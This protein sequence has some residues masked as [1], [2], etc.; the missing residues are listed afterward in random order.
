MKKVTLSFFIS[1]TRSSYYLFIAAIILFILNNSVYPQSR[2]AHG[3]LE[4]VPSRSR[5][6][7]IEKLSTTQDLDYTVEL[8]PG[9]GFTGYVYYWTWGSDT[10]NAHL[11]VPPEASSWLTVDPTSFS[12]DSCNDIKEV[13]FYFYAPDSLGDYETTVVDLDSNYSDVH[14][15]LI[16]TDAPS[17]ATIEGSVDQ[18]LQGSD[19]A[20]APLILNY[21]KFEMGCDTSYPPGNNQVVVLIIHPDHVPWLQLLDTVIVLSVNTPDT[22]NVP[23]TND[24]TGSPYDYIYYSA[25][26]YAHPAYWLYY[27]SGVMA[28]RG[29]GSEVI[30]QKFHLSQNYPNPFNPSTQ[31]EYTVS[32]DGYVKLSV[33]NILGQQIKNLV[34]ENKKAGSYHIT[35]DAS[36][37]A[38]GV[39]F[40][41]LQ[42]GS[43]IQTKKMILL[44]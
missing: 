20:S 11:M 27:K 29:P 2:G 1:L 23:V 4:S 32:K 10:L 30:P 24:T 7:I 38:S 33:F 21:E 26:Y 25:D 15:T 40:Y 36:N 39:Y 5:N 44:R 12:S 41:R 3:F 17:T 8:F 22:V 6:G 28:V 16:V 14:V 19:S 37:L 43:F 13:G 31:I 34:N 18:W 42:S 35:F 9:L